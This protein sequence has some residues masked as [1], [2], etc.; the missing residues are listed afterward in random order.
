MSFASR[1]HNSLEA[2]SEKNKGAEPVSDAL[3]VCV[4][5]ALWGTAGVAQ[6]LGPSSAGSLSVA[7]GR[8]TLGGLLLL[9]WVTLRHT[10]AEVRQCWTRKFWLRS[11]V[12]VLAVA[13]YQLLFFSSVRATGVAVGT[14]VA[15]GLA[16]V[17]SATLGH[18]IGEHLHGA[19]YIATPIVLGGIALLLL[20]HGIAGVHWG[21]VWLGACAAA[22]YAIY[23][24]MAR[25]LL[26]DGLTPTAVVGS[27]IGLAWI[28]LLILSVVVGMNFRWIASPS[29]AGM[30]VWLGAIA[31]ALPYVLWGRGLRSVTAAA[32]NV[33]GLTQVA[34][35]ATLAVLL[36]HEPFTSATAAGLGFV[37]L[38]QVVMARP[39]TTLLPLRSRS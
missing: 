4:S 38:G 15:T 5:A 26:S 8:M 7:T 2:P 36:L 11:A 1:S 6:A 34:V 28:P 9:L 20:P 29:G 33:L 22:A 32:A 39:W 17:I 23:T 10:T 19:F 21:G 37:V 14:L 25:S 24:V 13:A 3:L 31:T 30:V 12:G 35:A 27:L 16:P 18:R